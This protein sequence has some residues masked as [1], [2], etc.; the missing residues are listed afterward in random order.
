M[1][2]PAKHMLQ[3]KSPAT[4]ELAI[5][6]SANLPA[7]QIEQAGAPVPSALTPVPLLTKFSSS[8]VSQAQ[9]PRPAFDVQARTP[10]Q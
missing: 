7:A 9:L 3:G 1:Y 2:V 4:G 10:P 5:L 6:R 8:A